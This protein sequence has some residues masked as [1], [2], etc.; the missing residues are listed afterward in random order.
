[1]RH[2]SLLA[3]L[4]LIGFAASAASAQSGVA[5]WGRNHHGQSTVPSGTVGI[6]GIACGE[7]HTVALRGDGTVAC[8]G[9]N[10]HGQSTPPSGLSSVIQVAGG[11]SHS[12]ALRGN[13]S[14]VCWGENDLGQCT[15]PTGLGPVTQIDAGGDHT[16]ALRSGGTVVVWG[17]NLFGQRV[18][19]PGLSTV[20][21]V[22][23]G[24]EHNVAL[25]ANGTVACWGSNLE[26][27]C[28]VPPNLT[29]VVQVSAGEEHTLALR[30]DGSLAAWGDDQEGECDV[31]V[32]L[33]PM[34]QVAAGDD[35]N[36]GLLADGT[37]I[38][39]GRNDHGQVS[40]PPSLGRVIAVAAGEDHSAAVIA[41][42]L[43]GDGDG[44]VNSLDNC[45]TIPNPG[46]EDSD[47][48]G[49]GDACDPCDECAGLSAADLIVQDVATRE[50]AAWVV[51]PDALVASVLP[52]P[53]APPGFEV[54]ASGDFTGDGRRDVLTE[55]TATRQL[56]VWQLGGPTGTTCEAFEPLRLDGQPMVLPAKWTVQ[57]SA[58]F[59]GDG[60]RDLLIRHQGSGRLAVW[61]M[62][63]LAYVRS[64]FVHGAKTS[65][66][67]QVRGIEELAPGS[68]MIVFQH[69][70]NG[71]VL[72]WNLRNF[73]RTSQKWF[74]RADTGKILTVPAGWEVREARTFDDDPSPSLVLQ[75]AD[76]AVARWTFDQSNRWTGA[77]PIEVPSPSSVRIR[78]D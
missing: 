47:D 37:V 34:V 38:C 56:V 19:P 58:D 8:W 41:L 33:P 61:E 11:G 25:R 74:V 57:G 78:S 50:V 28:A 76:G 39:W 17:S 60:D 16:V 55:R 71:R 66:A 32:Y 7:Y 23:A 9:R 72:R 52:L 59:D 20:I 14:V 64:R 31:P 5:C 77:Q 75:S 36:V 53:V 15:V 63:G 30:A 67:L 54:V 48:D 44:L 22:S 4:P 21:Q 73:S 10:N 1:M 42:D 68:S 46:Q 13:G 29:G 2:A 49:I 62:Q 45:P 3:A 43:D 27:Q 51:T 18:V 35:H 40:V 69:R 26:G 65:L 70:G 12:V 24:D 6:V